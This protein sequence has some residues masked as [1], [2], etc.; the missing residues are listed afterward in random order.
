MAIVTAAPPTFS[1]GQVI[2]RTFGAIG[3][4]ALTFYLLSLIAVAPLLVMQIPT[5]AAALNA[6]AGST[7]GMSLQ[8]SNPRFALMF[9]VSMLVYIVFGFV[10]QATL[11]YGTVADLNGRRAPF[12]TCLSTG[13]GVFFPMVGIGIL[14]ALGVWLGLILL[15]VPGIMLAMRWIVAAPVRV[16]E[17]PGILKAMGR[18]AELTRGHRWPIFGLVIIFLLADMAVQ[19]VAGAI[20]GAAATTTDGAAVSV[21]SL[22]VTWLV[23]ALVAMFTAVGVA[24]TYYELRSIKEGIGPEHLAAVFS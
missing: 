2:N 23:G 5:R 20:T 4:N 10:L 8:F 15:I 16:I 9:A 1:I 12:G 19:A 17:G 24:S 6:S 14:V 7:A 18:S 3:R 22:V 11:V 21:V 13:L